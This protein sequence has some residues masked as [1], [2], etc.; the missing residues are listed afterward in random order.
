MNKKRIF[1]N[2]INGI[3]STFDRFP[4]VLSLSIVTTI[5]GVILIQKHDIEITWLSKLF[6]TTLISLPLSIAATLTAEK[7][8]K[9]TLTFSILGIFLILFYFLFSKDVFYIEQEIYKLQYF[10]WILASAALITIIPFIQKAVKNL[11]DFWH[12]NQRILYSALA[13]IFYSGAI[14]AGLAIA[15]ASINVLFDLK[16]EGIRW[17]QLA[18][19][20]AGLFSTTFFLSRF[21]GIDEKETDYPKEL[22]LFSFYVLMPLVAIYFLILYSYSGKII[23]T[24]E[25]P[26]G[27][28][29]SMILGFSMLGIF[30]YALVYPLTLK[31]GLLQKISKWFFIALLPQIVLLFLA[32]KLRISEYAITEQRY[33][34]VIF[35][36]WLLGMSLYF[37]I[38]KTKDIRIIAKSLFILIFLVSFGPW[39]AFDVSRDSQVQRLEKILI[40][41]NMLV[42]GKVA[43]TTTQISFK[44]RQ[45]ISEII[46]YLNLNH[47]LES[48]QPWFDTDLNNAEDKYSRAKRATELMGIYFLD[49]Y[50][51]T[52]NFYF[53]ASS[54]TQTNSMKI[55]GYDY[56]IHNTRVSPEMNY[57]E[58][59][60]NNSVYRFE[61]ATTTLEYIVRKNGIQVSQ[62]SIKEFIDRLKASYLQNGKTEFAS[63]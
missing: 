16:I 19:T 62:F 49:R 61:L 47:G 15:L 46:S 12:Y 22:R 3:K 7:Y 56:I 34:V 2:I 24:Q 32:V 55:A 21:P 40:N 53:T 11:S 14:F 54:K 23:F 52:Q 6:L 43:S 25:W 4:V 31:D 17:A 60:H 33:F 39:G 50:Q 1:E 51:N 28:I 35:G 20:I 5:L 48:I 10:L 30:T 38:S 8:N 27:I 45:E 57:G 26:K 44:D 9:K 63:E 41:N 42:G 13:T 37:L 58:I 18:V 29:S 36:A 59:T